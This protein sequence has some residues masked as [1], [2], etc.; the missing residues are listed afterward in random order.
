ML[1]NNVFQCRMF[2]FMRL[3]KHLV[4]QGSAAISLSYG[5]ICNDRFIANCAESSSE[6]ILKMY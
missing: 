5:W 1:Q 2:E 6:I 3:L 4:S